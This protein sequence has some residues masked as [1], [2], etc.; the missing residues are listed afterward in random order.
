MAR[1]RDL[2]LSFPCRLAFLRPS[3][4]AVCEVVVPAP[5][6]DGQ[7]GAVFGRGGE[8]GGDRPVLRGF[9]RLPG[10]LARRGLGQTACRPGRVLLTMNG[11][12][13]TE[14]LRRIQ[15]EVPREG[16]VAWVEVEARLRAII[17]TTPLPASLTLRD[18]EAF[19]ALRG[20]CVG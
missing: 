6:A 10:P 20:W 8:Q 17:Q 16:A 3:T 2:E 14:V 15:A 12:P 11:N 5:P 18:M 9:R 19:A 1:L 4:G 7:W 13:L